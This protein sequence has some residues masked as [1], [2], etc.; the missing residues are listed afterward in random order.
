M[1]SETSEL[2]EVFREVGRGEDMSYILNE[3]LR[4]VRT[5]AAWEAFATDNGGQGMLAT[6][7]RG[8]S[9]LDAISGPLRAYYEA[10]FAQALRANMPWS[11]E[12]EC[13]SADEYRSFRMLAYPF[14]GFLVVTHTPGVVRLHDRPVASPNETYF[15]DGVLTMCSECRRARHPLQ[16]RWDW[17]PAFVAALPAR[18]NHDLCP[19]CALWYWRPT[20]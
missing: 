14:S 1:Q 8:A 5:S 13:S 17:V 10:G 19:S 2:L 3:E 4:L 7:G 15:E 18:V 12:Y 6:W 9:V 16:E 11:H 20:M